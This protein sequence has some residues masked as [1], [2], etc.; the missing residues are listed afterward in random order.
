MGAAQPGAHTPCPL[1]RIRRLRAVGA[2]LAS[3]RSTTIPPAAARSGALHAPRTTPRPLI[4]WKLFY[5]NRNQPLG[6]APP[7]APVTVTGKEIRSRGKGSGRGWR[8][9]RGGARRA[10]RRSDKGVLL[11]WAPRERERHRGHGHSSAPAIAE[12]G[13]GLG[14]TPT[15][16]R[17]AG[18]QPPGFQGSASF[19]QP[20]TPPT[21]VGCFLRPSALFWALPPTPSCSERGSGSGQGNQPQAPR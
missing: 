1:H 9:G 7:S 20:P 13:A 16:H 15:P 2:A 17:A 14:G 8:P 11:I 6:A 12:Q 21:A 10:E 4:K 18:P 19:S 5:S 3:P